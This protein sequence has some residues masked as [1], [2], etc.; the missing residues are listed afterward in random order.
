MKLGSREESWGAREH[1]L[2]RRRRMHDRYWRDLQDA[3]ACPGHSR[4]SAAASGRAN[5]RLPLWEPHALPATDAGRQALYLHT[6]PA[7]LIS[8][9]ARLLA[10]GC[11]L[12]LHLLLLSHQCR[13]VTEQLSSL[14][15][16]AFLCVTWRQPPLHCPAPAIFDRRLIV[17]DPLAVQPHPP[18]TPPSFFFF[19]G[20]TCCTR[21]LA[22]AG[23]RLLPGLAWP[24]F[25]F[26]VVLVPS[27]LLTP[28]LYD[29]RA[30]KLIL[31]GPS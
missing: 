11:S 23:L 3:S 4:S 1:R 8:W 5:I 19:F 10:A 7:P 21:P 13:R 29:S 30:P 12:V 25:F 2:E 22:A 27:C 28:Q 20:K 15:V 18:A 17:R 6:R 9:P 14:R 16:V 26:L 24:E 31:L